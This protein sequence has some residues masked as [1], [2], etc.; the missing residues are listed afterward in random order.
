MAKMAKLRSPYL[1]LGNRMC[2]DISTDVSSIVL[3]SAYCSIAAFAFIAATCLFGCGSQPSGQ[4]GAIGV[5]RID[6]TVIFEET[7]SPNKDYTS[8]E[9]DIV[10]YTVRVMQDGSGTATVSAESNSGF[11]DPVSYQVE[12]DGDLTADDV[13]VKWTTLMGNPEPSEDDQIAIAVVSV[14]TADD[15]VDERKI[16][17]VT[18][19]LEIAAE[20]IPA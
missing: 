11:F 13:S 15:I 12:C 6:G 7:I 16:N 20:A 17:F 19:A 18:R 1:H 4:D 3:R 2:S 10:Y 14:Q 8:S 9:D 5:E